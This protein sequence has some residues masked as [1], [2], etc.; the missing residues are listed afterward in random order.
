MPQAIVKPEDLETFAKN[1]KIFNDHLKQNISI[2]NGQF[3]NIGITWRD[4]EHV[5]YAF[6]FRETMKVIHHFIQTSDEQIPFLLRKAQ[7]AREY[8]NQK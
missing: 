4:Q 7:R 1:L 6:E 2:L 8:L 5:K 3:N